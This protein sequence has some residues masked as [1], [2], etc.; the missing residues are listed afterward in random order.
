MLAE[1]SLD[2]LVDWQQSLAGTPV[3]LADELS[4]EG[5]DDAGDGRGLALADEVEIQHALHSPRLETVNEA[6]C[7]VVEESVR[8]QRA[9]R[10]AGS[11]KALDLVVGRQVL[12]AIG[13]GGCHGEN[14]VRLLFT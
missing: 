8:R 3:H 5:I 13:T 6:S 11:S 10:A 4:A 2:L 9:Q 12:A 14:R 7:L 1:S